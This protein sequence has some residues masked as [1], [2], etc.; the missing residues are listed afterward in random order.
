MEAHMGRPPIGKHAMTDAERQQR[1]RAAHPVTKPAAQPAAQV[2]AESAA[3]KREIAALKALVA[4]RDQQI[5][6][7]K[8]DL[9]ALHAAAPADSEALH[10]QLIELKAEMGRWR[11]V[12]ESRYGGMSRPM[13]DLVLDCL[14]PNSRRAISDQDLNRALDGFR[15]L[16]WQGIPSRAVSL[17]QRILH[18]D[19]R[20]AVSKDDRAA[21]YNEFNKRR[22][23]LLNNTKMPVKDYHLTV[24]EYVK[25]GTKKGKPG[26]THSTRTITGSGRST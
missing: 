7:L 21:A 11:T 6:S 14:N 16:Q 20:K 19:S 18:P 3:L 25:R 9:Q 10:E 15:Q 17:I 26:G 1:H 24:E 12:I 13:F 2:A 23:L 5:A 4:E 8:S 22:L